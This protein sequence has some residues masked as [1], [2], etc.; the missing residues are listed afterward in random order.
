MVIDFGGIRARLQGRLEILRLRAKLALLNLLRPIVIKLGSQDEKEQFAA[1]WATHD[2]EIG[3][4]WRSV[5]RQ[6][7]FTFV[8]LALSEWAGMEDSLVAI[9]SL[10]LRTHEANKVG[11]ILYSIINPNTWLQ[12]IGDLFSQEPLYISLKP[13]WNKIGERIRNLND[14]RVRLA[15][16]TIYYGDKAT[17]LAGDTSLKPGQFD[18][19]PKSQKHRFDPLDYDQISE[20]IDSVGEIVKDLTALLN[21]MTTLLT[22]ETSQRKSSEP[23]SDQRHQ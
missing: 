8:G 20:F 17:T 2:Q 12:I 18:I 15:H 23:T 11:I 21:S 1:E 3:E 13:R 19:R 14:T 9:T 7:L 22:Q 16:H 5:H 10:L 6:R 4:K